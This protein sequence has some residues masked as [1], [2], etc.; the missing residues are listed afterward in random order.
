MK[1]AALLS[2]L[3]LLALPLLAQEPP[4]RSAV[5]ESYCSVCH[6]SDGRGE[7]EEGLKKRARNLT[8]AKWQ[9]TVSDGRLTSS[10]QRGHEKMPA[11]G[12]KLSE[13]QVRALVAEIRALAKKGT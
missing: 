8:D 3:A 6:G 7:T 10:I 2:S 11:F 1:P 12:K 9:A 5:W 13:E 4:K